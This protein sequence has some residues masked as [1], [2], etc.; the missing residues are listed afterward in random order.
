MTEALSASVVIATRDR[1]DDL[2]R[3]LEC[4]GAQRTPRRFEVIVVDDG[5]DPAVEGSTLPALDGLTLIRGTGEGPAR[6]RN[7]GLAAAAAPIVLFTD[8]DTLPDPAW[9]EAACA[10]LEAHAESVG[11][12][13]PIDSLPYDRLFEL[14]LET[15]GPGAYFTANVGYRRETLQSLG[16]LDTGFPYPHGED[17]DLAFRALELGGIGYESAMRVRHV[18]RPATI[19]QVVRRARYTPSEL[20]LHARHG[21]RYGRGGRLP[22]PVFVLLNVARSWLSVARDEGTSLVRPPTR[23]LRLC[24]M[25]AGQLLVAGVATVRALRSA[26]PPAR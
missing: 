22:G 18:P 3:C 13:G 4:L 11:V 5:S 7:R 1:H 10:H 25:A 9:V 20:T 16:G 24:A 2:R 19:G 26:T 14:S 6:A 12:E 15:K 8:D 17:L 23:L 21:A